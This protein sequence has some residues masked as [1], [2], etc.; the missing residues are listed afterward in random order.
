MKVQLLTVGGLL[1]LHWREFLNKNTL[2]EGPCAG[3]NAWN[4]QTCM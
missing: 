2:P 3:Q 1:P 4:L